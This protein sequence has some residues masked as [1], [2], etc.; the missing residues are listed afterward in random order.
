MASQ[1]VTKLVVS[2]EGGE[3]TVQGTLNGVK[4]QTSRGREVEVFEQADIDAIRKALEGVN[5][6]GTPSANSKPDK[7]EKA[8]GKPEG[9]P[10]RGPEPK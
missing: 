5:G 3:V 4:I 6:S 8:S 7:A 10:G 1:S 9:T 2:A